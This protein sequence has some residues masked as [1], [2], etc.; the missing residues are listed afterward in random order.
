MTG[1][2]QRPSRFELFEQRID[3]RARQ[4]WNAAAARNA[5]LIGESHA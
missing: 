1:G 3:T 4:R 2:S 5:L